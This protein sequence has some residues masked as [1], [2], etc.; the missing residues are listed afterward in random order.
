M[1]A[2]VV[3][4][5]GASSGVGRAAAAAF[6]RRG[7]ALGLLARGERGL[8]GVEAEVRKLGARA[9][10]I[11]TDVA[12]PDAVEAAAAGVEGELGPLGVWVNS[13]MVSVFSS[14]RQL[15]ADEVRRVTEVTYL[16]TVYGTL[17]AL[18]RM[19][20]R[21]DGVIVQVGSA[22]SYR[23]IPLQAPYCAAKH[24]VNGF[25]ESLRCELLHDAS[26]V[27]LTTVQLPAINTPHFDVVRSHLPR[28]PRPVPPVYQPEVAAEAI[29]W[30]ADN[31]RREVW[32]APSTVK[33]ILGDRVAPGVLD[34]YLAGRAYDAQQTEE[35][36]D[37][38]RPDNLW[39]PV[40]VQSAHGSF[41]RESRR[42][43]SLFWLT[44]HRTAAAGLLGLAGLAALGRR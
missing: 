21:D 18:R 22:L 43:S 23:A 5:T 2:R 15:A 34:W 41:D 29:V 42:S 24:A 4:I 39:E 40:P 35:S 9:V 28:R 32:V 20:P 31:P 3:V 11:P 12:D 27:R 36:V 19:L 38:N 44:R 14:V 17:A 16:G 7:D 26:G 13:A 6:A 33:A 30:A 1:S 25:T 37:G 10:A 8:L